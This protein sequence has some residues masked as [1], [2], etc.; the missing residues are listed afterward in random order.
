[1]LLLHCSL[2]SHTLPE[3]SDNLVFT[4]TPIFLPWL[5]HVAPLHRHTVDPTLLNNHS[6]TTKPY[7]PKLQPLKPLR[8]F[9]PFPNSLPLT[10]PSFSSHSSL[11]RYDP[12]FFVFGFPFFFFLG[13]SRSKYSHELIDTVI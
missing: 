10:K 2:F 7:T 5:S 4:P 12:F 11:P 6:S 1:M 9:R 3:L 13:Y 8:F